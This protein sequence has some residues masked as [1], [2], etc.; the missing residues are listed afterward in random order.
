MGHNSLRALKSWYRL[1]QHKVER[2]LCMK[3]KKVMGRQL[4]FFFLIYIGSKAKLQWTKSFEKLKIVNSLNLH[5]RRSS[6]A[7]YTTT[8]QPLAP[9]YPAA[10]TPAYLSLMC[11][12]EHGRKPVSLSL[13]YQRCLF[14]DFTM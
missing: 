7:Y 6:T 1:I 12:D 2:D 3:K 14:P 8:K 9:Y 5:Q 13:Y 10:F 4:I 11:R